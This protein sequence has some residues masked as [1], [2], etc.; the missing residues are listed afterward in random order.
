M[1]AKI[2]RREVLKGTGALVV[3]F[4]LFGPVSDVL[5]QLTAGPDRAGD[6][7]ATSL[8]SWIAVGRDGVVTVFSS[9]VDLG[10]GVETALGQIVADEL[11]VEFKQIKMI[12]GD[13]TL[14][15]DQGITAGSRTIELAGP[16][17]R[18]AAAAARQE[19]LKLAS[20]RLGAPVSQ[21]TVTDGVVSVMGN[22]KKV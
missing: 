15:V 20:A 11:D 6:L 8:D 22:G 17:L 13:T 9:K 4:N 5:A 16:Q 7:Q 14:A 2:S 19:L 10:T 21:L 12:T 3:S 18:H 1:K